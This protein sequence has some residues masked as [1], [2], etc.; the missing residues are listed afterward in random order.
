MLLALPP[1][2]T[3]KDVLEAERINK[4]TLLCA[5]RVFNLAVSLA[6]TII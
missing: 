4:I 2:Y 1:T 3:Y 6:D 5:L